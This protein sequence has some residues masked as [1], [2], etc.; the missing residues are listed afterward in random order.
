MR[1]RHETS[2]SINNLRNWG[3]GEAIRELVQNTVFAKAILKDTIEISHH[4]D[5]AVLKNHPSGF[6]KGKLLIGEST[7][8]DVS[9]APGQYGEGMKVAMAVALREGMKVHALTNGFKVVPTLE[10]SSLDPSVQVLV[11]NIEDN[12]HQ[13]GTEFVIDCSEGELN[14]AVSYFAILNGVPLENTNCDCIIPTE[15]PGVYINGVKV[16]SIPS[17]FSYNFTD[18]KIMNRD[19][20]SVNMT[21]LKTAVATVLD[22]LSNV[23]SAAKVFSAIVEDSTLLEA[24][25]SP[26]LNSS[27][28]DVWKAAVA[29]T[30]GTEKLAISTGG[31]TD[32]RARYHKFTLLTNVPTYWTY[33][34]NRDL[35]IPYTH[36][37]PASQNGPRM[38]HRKPSGAESDNLSW[39]KRL[40]KMYY[41][42]YGTVKVSEHVY[43]DYGMEVN[44]LHDPNTDTTWLKR[45][46]L[47]SREDTFKALVHETA[48]RLTGC[49]DNT[50]GFTRELERACWLILT[51]GKGD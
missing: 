8:S 17:V 32:T 7:Q 1:T 11:F 30:M 22:K 21:R 46:L 40:V 50:T 45:M 12:D 23:E 51:R 9:G 34:L 49:G 5:R 20:N 6:T 33:F 39:C 26:L 48:H 41:G 44:A 43:D 47:S 27:N 4:G 2:I 42:D 37:L 35:G 19:R 13:G 38:Y 36:S 25:V 10:P 15:Y 14:E 31:E 18:T 24:Q 28:K 29:S 16:S 3:R